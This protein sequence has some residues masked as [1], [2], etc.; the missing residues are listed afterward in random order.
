MLFFYSLVSVF[1]IE[2][3]LLVTGAYLFVEADD[4]CEVLLDG[5]LQGQ[6]PLLISGIHGESR[7]LKILGSRGMAEVTLQYD[8]SMGLST[9][10]P[11]LVDYYGTLTLENLSSHSEV[12]I[13]GE[14][15]ET[16]GRN[17]LQLSSGDRIVEIREDGFYSKE[18]TLSVP[19]LE[20]INLD[21]A[22]QEAFDILFEP[23]IPSGVVL[24]LYNQENDDQLSLQG[25]E[26]CRLY[27][28]SWQL[29]VDDPRYQAIS[30]V[31]EIQE[32]Q[33]VEL[34]YIPYQ[35]V[36]RISGITPGS[37][38]HLN[39]EIIPA[40]QESLVLDIPVGESI[41]LIEMEEYLPIEELILGQGNQIVELPLE[42]QRDPQVIRGKRTNLALTLIGSGAAIL[43]GGLIVNNDDFL[44]DNTSD[45]ESY[46]ALKYTS[47]G[48]SGAGL[49]TMLTGAFLWATVFG[50]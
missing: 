18:V 4:H 14:L 45:Y 38:I 37:T 36:L 31:L 12:L 15:Q 9:F 23:P 21:C 24:S 5:Q 41:L 33:T 34:S 46:S 10:I 30:T 16:N 25:G 48:V 11:S 43:A 35:P 27:S 50:E 1:S 39:D 28:G 47:L 22:L 29:T 8:E 26:P 44:V 32:S 42:Y 17:S 7:E 40:A 6:T 3:E 13:D 49:G 20:T 2:Q 19:R